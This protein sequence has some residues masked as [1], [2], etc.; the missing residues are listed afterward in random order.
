MDASLHCSSPA[1]SSDSVIAEM[2]VMRVRLATV[3]KLKGVSAVSMRCMPPSVAGYGGFRLGQKWNFI[4]LRGFDPN[5]GK[6]GQ[7]MR[8]PAVDIVFVNNFA[9]A[10]YASGLLLGAQ[11]Q[12]LVD[13][14]GELLDVIGIDEQSVGEFVRGSGKRTEDQGTLFILTG[15]NEFLGNEIHSVVKRRDQANRGSPVEAGDLLMGVV[16][17][18]KNNGLPVAN[19]KP[20]VDSFRFCIDLLH[21]L[22]IARNVRATGSTNLHQGEAALVSRMKLKE[23]FDPA[24]PFDDPLGVVQAIDT[25]SEKRRFDAQLGTKYAALLTCAAR[26]LRFAIGLGKCHADGIRAYASDMA[27]AING[28]AVPLGQ[29]FQGVIHRFQEIVAV[30]LNVKTDQVGSE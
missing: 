8:G 9:H 20:V 5:L 30:R 13:G 2:L 29:S 10:G 28:E 18:E 16:P 3:K 27:L 19:L 1:R 4:P 24:E 23:A 26:R 6:I 11:V 25:D 7:K 12:G 15:S 22:L 17:H 21:E 14:I